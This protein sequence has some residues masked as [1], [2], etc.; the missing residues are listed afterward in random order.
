MIKKKKIF[1]TPENSNKISPKREEREIEEKNNEK[2][3]KYYLSTF[4]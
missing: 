1:S 4:L 2:L 3:I